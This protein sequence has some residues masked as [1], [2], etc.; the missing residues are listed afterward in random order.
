MQISRPIR[1]ATLLMAGLASA[2]LAIGG[3]RTISVSGQGTATSPP[4]LAEFDAAVVTQGESAAAALESNSAA[5]AKM[6]E[7]LRGLKIADKDIQTSR[8]DLS[9]LYENTRNGRAP[10]IVGYTASNQV[11]VRVRNL[12]QLGKVLDDLIESGSNQISGIRFDLDDKTGVLNQARNRA[13]S[14]AR[15]RAELFAH[16]AGVKVGQVLSIQ[17]VSSS[18]PQPRYAIRAMAAEAAV[19]MATG[20][21]EISA[22]VSVV[23]EM[24]D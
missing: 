9:P 6:L 17:E 16:A 22:T 7:V 2:P 20:E 5:V 11:H 23:Y 12:P 8:F 18:F 4:D 14:D 1:I 24:L 19:P 21:Q 10:K 15:A 3:E 13:M